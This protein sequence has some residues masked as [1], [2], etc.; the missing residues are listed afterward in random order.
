VPCIPDPLGIV[1]CTDGGTPVATIPPCS[2]ARKRRFGTHLNVSG[3]ASSFACLCNPSR[4]LFRLLSTRSRT[5][6]TAD[7]TRSLGPCLRRTRLNLLTTQGSA[8]PQA[9]Q[10]FRFNLSQLGHIIPTLTDSG[11]RSFEPG[12]GDCPILLRPSSAFT[13]PSRP[14]ADGSICQ[15]AR[16]PIC[17]E[18]LS[19][20]I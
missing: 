3:V 16:N 6:S 10:Y 11:Y 19:R 5:I 18:S 20:H 4:V 1:P 15:P 17:P 12:Q 13:E 8:R 2:P 9:I 7:G 14:P